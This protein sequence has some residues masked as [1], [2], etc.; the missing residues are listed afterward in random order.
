MMI[1]TRESLSLSRACYYTDG[2]TALLESVVPPEGLPV[3]RASVA[4]ARAAGIPDR[5]IC[6]CL[7]YGL[8]ATPE[9]EMDRVWC[10]HACWVVRGV[11]ES[12]RAAGRELHID[13]WCAVEMVERLVRGEATREELRSAHLDHSISISAYLAADIG[14]GLTAS[15][16]YFAVA[17]ASDFAD[18]YCAAV[19][20]LVSRI[21]RVCLKRCSRAVSHE[22]VARPA[23][24]DQAE[25][26]PGRVL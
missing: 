23:G 13:S 26:D 22:K 2:R 12:E 14:I 19:N 17:R 9:M 15:A 10:E 20:D 5:D 4:T 8:E 25:D 21:E 11:L 18:V 6:W 7:C 24:N 16:A 3:T 1:V